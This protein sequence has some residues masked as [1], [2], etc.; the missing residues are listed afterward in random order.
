MRQQLPASFKRFSTGAAAAGSGGGLLA[1]AQANPFV[2]QLG[3]STV[4]TGAADILTQTTVEGKGFW[5]IDWKR[6]MVFV[7]FGAAYLGGFQYWIQVNMFRKWFPGMDRFANST[8]AQ[9]LKDG[10]GMLSA[11]KQVCFDV[12]VHLPFMYFP[13]FYSVKESVQGSS[14]NPVDWVKDGCTKYYNNFAKDFQVMF[15]LWAPADVVLF[16]LPMWLRMPGRHMVSFGWTA[17]LSFLRGGAQ[18]EAPKKD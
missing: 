14:W 16:S 1:F 12:F 15:T 4:K 18:V 7:L 8:M 11:A 6:N 13:V 9:K 10:P 17:Y 5:E 2:T 3:V